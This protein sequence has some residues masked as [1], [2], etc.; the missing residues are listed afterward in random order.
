MSKAIS[1]S[2]DS[3]KIKRLLSRCA[4]EGVRSVSASFGTACTG[5]F[6]LFQ[7]DTT[8]RLVIVVQ[9][10]KMG[11]VA[12]EKLGMQS[13]EATTFFWRLPLCASLCELDLT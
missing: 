10:K 3:M 11:R 4:K 5:A 7:F 9:G 12:D 13:K 2:G 6:L 8:F 1:I